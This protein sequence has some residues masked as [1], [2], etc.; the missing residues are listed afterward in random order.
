MAG[1]DTHS[2]YVHCHDKGKGN[3]PCVIQQEYFYCNVLTSDQQAKFATLK[4]PDKGVVKEKIPRKHSTPGK[5]SNSDS[6]LKALDHKW[7][8]RFTRL[9]TMLVA[10]TL[11]KP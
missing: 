8:E 11:E 7:S 6:L 5:S 10:S 1:F 9:Q 2:H 3:D 4:S